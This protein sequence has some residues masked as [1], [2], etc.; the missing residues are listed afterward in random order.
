M[1]FGGIF[2]AICY[3][4]FFRDI[5][6]IKFAPEYFKKTIEENIEEGQT[7]YEGSVGEEVLPQKKS[8]ENES[9]SVEDETKGT[10]KQ[11]KIS[12]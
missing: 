7:S 10:K 8:L 1:F 2:L 11:P 5:D 4:C 6:K 9:F 12:V 3:C